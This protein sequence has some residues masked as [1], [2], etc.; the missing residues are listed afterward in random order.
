MI[1]LTQV[2]KRIRIEDIKSAY[3]CNS[4]DS[5]YYIERSIRALETPF[6]QD[7]FLLTNA[8]QKGLQ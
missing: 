5:T 3:L 1:C 4:A 8:F 6:M 2:L 7:I